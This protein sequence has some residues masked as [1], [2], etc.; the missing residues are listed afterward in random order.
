MRRK[1]SRQ[2]TEAY[3]KAVGLKRTKFVSHSSTR[4]KHHRARRGRTIRANAPQQRNLAKLQA[5]ALSNELHCDA[6]LSDKRGKRAS[7]DYAW[8]FSLAQ[9]LIGRRE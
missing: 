6:S 3:A 1:E 8:S 2:Y 7:P 4:K 9:P 5:L